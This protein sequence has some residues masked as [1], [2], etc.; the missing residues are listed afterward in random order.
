[1][2]IAVLISIQP[3][4][5]Q[6][7]C[8]RIGEYAE[9]LPIFKKGV[10]IRKTRPKIETPFKAY[11][12]CTKDKKHTFFPPISQQVL[13]ETPHIDRRGNGK[14]IGEFI[15]N[16][17]A[18][19]IKDGSRFIAEG[20]TEA[21][22]NRIARSSCLNFDDMKKYLGAK[23]GYAWYISNLVI[24]DKPKK[25]SEFY[26]VDNEAVKQCEHRERVYTNPDYTNGACLWG[27]YVCNKGETDWCTKCKVKPITKPPQSWCYVE[28][29]RK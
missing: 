9:D 6:N 16:D 8:Y 22:T 15:C 1:M 20:R 26:T 3:Y 14:V 19:I 28:E 7:I 24:Y 12:Y 5:C 27:S 23:D 18:K 29:L 11:I 2:S 13:N 10:E 25:L 21:E 17:I 4:W